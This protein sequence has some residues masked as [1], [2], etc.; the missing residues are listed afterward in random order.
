MRFLNCPSHPDVILH[1]N[2]KGTLVEERTPLI[3][4]MRSGG[5]QSSKSS[6][7]VRSPT[8]KRYEGEDEEFDADFYGDDNDNARRFIGDSDKVRA[9]EEQMESAKGG[10]PRGAKKKAGQSARKSALND[11][12][13]AWEENRLLTSGVAHRAKVDTDFDNELDQRVQL[14]VRNVR[15][16]FLDGRVSFSKQ[17][18][19]QNFRT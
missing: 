18:V 17:M 8:Q 19:S 10:R 14:Q 12:Q 2:G 15:P 4:P 11:D 13:N 6:T 7:L 3:S 1:R 5:D 16:K 9:H